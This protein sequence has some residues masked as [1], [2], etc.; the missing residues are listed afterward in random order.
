MI[1]IDIAENFVKLEDID[2]EIEIRT[3]LKKELVGK[4][5]PSILDDEI[6]RL[7]RRRLEILSI[8]ELNFEYYGKR[9][10]N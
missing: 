8:V 4:L 3:N 7:A 6:Y 5:Y 10:N 2:H 9:R 1:N